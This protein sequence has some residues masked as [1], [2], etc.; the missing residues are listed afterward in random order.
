MD[1]VR[2][3]DCNRCG[4]CCHYE[5]TVRLV[6]DARRDPDYWLAR[7]Y[8]IRPDGCVQVMTDIGLP[9]AQFDG[10]KTCA[11]YATRPK[12]CRDFPEHP[13]QVEDI[14]CSYWFERIGDDGTIERRGGEGS[15]YPTSEFR[16]QLRPMT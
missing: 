7:G 2:Q 9:C 14:P 5:V 15:P 16:K 6:R 4:W 12:T 11:I 1:W 10:E 13:D 8:K 3:G